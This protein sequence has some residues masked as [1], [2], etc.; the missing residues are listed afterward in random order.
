MEKVKMKRGIYLI[1]MALFL[2]SAGYALT[3]EEAISKFRN[4]MRSI[5]TMS[6]NISWTHSSGE[7][8]S[9]SFKY[10]A[11]GKI[12]VTLDSPSGKTIVSNGNT[13][14]VYDV[15]NNICGIQ[16]L[17][18]PGSGGI[19]GMISGYM[20]IA[21]PSSSGYTI[22][23]RN[24]EKYYTDIILLVDSSFLLRRALLKTGTDK[25]I[26]IFLSGV[27]TGVTFNP[28]IFTF[29]VPDDAQIVN[30]PFNIR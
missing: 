23:L 11:P 13:L 22:K 6:G 15:A 16:D 14:W 20:G 26:M 25:T 10:M 18:N 1:V 17:G 2:V 19:I 21:T 3:G 30:T 7:M 29:R 12:H 24:D 5:K 9:G 4:R 8:Y 27:R 28:G